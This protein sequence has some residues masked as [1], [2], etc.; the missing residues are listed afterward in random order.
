MKLVSLLIRFI[1]C[2]TRFLT[3]A[4]TSVQ[5]FN[6]MILKLTIVVWLKIQYQK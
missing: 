5:L 3:L 2:L 1:H 6:A 4:Q